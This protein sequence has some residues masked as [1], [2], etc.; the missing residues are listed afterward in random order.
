ML[1][2]ILGLIYFK[3][4]HPEMFSI[5]LN[6]IFAKKQVLFHVCEMMQSQQS[7][8]RNDLGNPPL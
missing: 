1:D 4:T 6:N 3:E 2:Q 8:Y 5:W 7:S